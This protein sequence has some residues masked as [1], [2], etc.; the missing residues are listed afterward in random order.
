LSTILDPGRTFVDNSGR[1]LSSGTITFYIPGSSS[2]KKAIYPTAADQ[3]AQTNALSNP[4]TLSSAGRLQTQVHGPGAYRVIVKNTTGATILD[5]DNVIAS[6][7]SYINVTD[8]GA[9]GDG[10]TDDTTAIQAAITALSTGGGTIYF[11]KGTYRTTATIN[12]ENIGITLL[13]DGTGGI[14][15]S[16]V[17]SS[18]VVGRGS[19]VGSATVIYGDFTS[20]PVLRFKSQDGSVQEMTINGS[21]TRKAASLSTNY[22]IWVEAP[23]TGSGYESTRRFYAHRV[24]VVNQPSHAW[25]L[26]NDIVSSRLDFCTASFC[27]GHGFLIAGGSFSSRTNRTRTGQIDVWNC[28]AENT[29]GHS[30]RVGGGEVDTT[31]DCYRVN[32]QNL[33]AYYNCIVPTLCVNHPTPS[34]AYL[35]GENITM[36]HSAID[37]RTLYPSL[38]DTHTAVEIRGRFID[39]NNNR[40]IDGNPYAIKLVGQATFSNVTKSVFIRNPY[41]SNN[42]QSAGFYNPA[43]YYSTD[44]FDIHV[45]SGD[46]FPIV[47]KLSSRTANS[48]YRELNE[49]L[50]YDDHDNTYAGTNTFSAGLASTTITAHNFRANT[51]TDFTMADDTAAYINM[52]VATRGV[53]FITGNT[54]AGG[55]AMVAFRCG[56]ANAHATIMS[57]AS[58]GPT[59]TGGTGTLAGTTGTDTHLTIRADTATNRVYVENRTGASRTY[60]YAFLALNGDTSSFSQIVAV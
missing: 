29:G 51:T 22:G 31:D 18:G 44:C 20:G 1:V 34:N 7:G 35:A 42:Y 25:V 12:V 40:F 23:D 8:Y 5:E 53:F 24:R 48:F 15:T 32:I 6:G 2:T 54:L 52:G 11:P 37:G 17:G 41:I 39:I 19:V 30:I 13:G 43:V 45:E 59:V 46:S 14:V 16:V 58:G 47:A 3:A 33:E 49:G 26:V 38:S 9:T 28:V 36:T 50:V 55:V 56:D 27:N 57:S 4:Q 21:T 10:T 60:N